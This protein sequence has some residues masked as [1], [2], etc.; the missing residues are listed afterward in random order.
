M[1]QLDAASATF[2]AH[3]FFQILFCRAALTCKARVYL[4]KFRVNWKSWSC[5][6][7]G[8]AQRALGEHSSWIVYD[9]GYVF[10][11]FEQCSYVLL[12]LM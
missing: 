6:G 10:V 11:V 9:G 8:K 2:S 7:C 1:L 3:W 12:V 4:M 5:F